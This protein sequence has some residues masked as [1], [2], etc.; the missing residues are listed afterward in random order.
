MPRVHSLEMTLTSILALCLSLSLVA[1]KSLAAEE[2]TCEFT[3][4][5]DG[6][7]ARRMRLH[8]DTDNRRLSLLPGSS[9]SDGWVFEERPASIAYDA[10]TLILRQDRSTGEF[11]MAAIRADIPTIVRF[12]PE[13]G[14]M[15]Y[16]YVMFDKQLTFRYMC[17]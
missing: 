2:F 7:E 14:K 13:S 11:L 8:I 4:G 5:D 3:D 17:R 1:G 12:N 9:N 16:S 10:D 15:T 6:R